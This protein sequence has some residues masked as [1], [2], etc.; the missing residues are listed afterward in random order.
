MK[1]LSSPVDATC[2]DKL[3]DPSHE[4][5]M[6]GTSSCVDADDKNL[7]LSPTVTPIDT[8]KTIV[9]AITVGGEEMQKRKLKVISDND[10]HKRRRTEKGIQNGKER[11]PLEN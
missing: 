4:S 10:N 11:D 9:L 6:E 2:S 7:N 5:C 1:P 8:I 3:T